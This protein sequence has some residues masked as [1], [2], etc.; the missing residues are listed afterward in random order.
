MGCFYE[1]SVPNSAQNN[2][3]H[4]THKARKKFHG[5]SQPRADVGIGIGQMAI[6]E[7][8]LRGR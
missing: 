1:L 8:P 3:Y 2:C 6:Y 4:R 5:R 7:R